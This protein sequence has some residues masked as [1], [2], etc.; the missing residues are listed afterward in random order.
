MD[1]LGLYRKGSCDQPAHDRDGAVIPGTGG[2]ALPSAQNNC[3]IAS[4]SL[5]GV[6]SG[7]TM[8]FAYSDGRWSAGEY[9]VRYF[10][11][12]SENGQGYVCR[13]LQGSPTA[14]HNYCALEYKTMSSPIDVV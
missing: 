1:W 8:R 5:P 6:V 4:Q 12:D 3:D 11:G 2:T 13:R 10:L 9:E 14:A 7:G